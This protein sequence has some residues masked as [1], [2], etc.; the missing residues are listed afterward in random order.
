MSPCLRFDLKLTEVNSQIIPKPFYTSVKLDNSYSS[1]TNNTAWYFIAIPFQVYNVPTSSYGLTALGGRLQQPILLNRQNCLTL[2]SVISRCQCEL[3]VMY[4]DYFS[5][6]N[7][8]ESEFL[9]VLL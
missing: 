7:D 3:P 9:I 8:I 2:A 1:V 5:N 6:P 4:L